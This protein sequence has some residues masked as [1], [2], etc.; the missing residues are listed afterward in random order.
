MNIS[1]KNFIIGDTL[2]YDFNKTFDCIIGNPP[3]IRTKNLN[4]NYLKKLKSNY[5]STEKGNVDIY[6]AFIELSNKIAT[7]ASF[8]VPN[9][10]ITNKSAKTLRSLIKNNIVSIIDFKNKLIFKN[11]STYTS[12]FIINKNVRNENILY[13]NSIKEKFIEKSRK[14]I[15]NDHW[16][17]KNENSGENTIENFATI[18]SGIA[19]LKDKIYIIENP[20]QE[21]LNNTTY[22]KHKYLG[23]E[24]LIEKDIAIDF[25]KITKSNKKYKIIFP[26][27]EDLN[28]LKEE[29]LKENFPKAYDFFINCQF[30][31]NQRDKGKVDKYES[32]YAY[33]RKQ[34]LSKNDK[35]YY[36][37]VPLMISRGFKCKTLTNPTNFLFSSG[38]ILEFNEIEDLNEIQKVIESEYFF[39]F[40]KNYGKPWAGKKEYFSFT[41]TLLKSFK[42]NK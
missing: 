4:E 39:N 25:Y 22:Y 20:K 31:L 26:Y 30:D 34:G 3:Y 29:N 1:T 8:I 28:I 38:F 37:L 36:L 18:K 9:S 7:K 23:K 6:Y 16:I 27:T 5:I 12:I 2:F 14:K 19:T 11:V 13:K 24:Y 32:W 17:F 41:T 35:K 21:I 40:V 15:N 10:Y 33:G 42:F